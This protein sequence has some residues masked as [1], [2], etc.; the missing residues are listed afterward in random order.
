MIEIVFTDLRTTLHMLLLHLQHLDQQFP[1]ACKCFPALRNRE[2]LCKALVNWFIL[3]A[4]FL[5]F[6]THNINMECWIINSLTVRILLTSSC[7]RKICSAFCIIFEGTA[8]ALFASQGKNLFCQQWGN[9]PREKQYRRVRQTHSSTCY[10]TL[11]TK[12]AQ[13]RMLKVVLKQ[14]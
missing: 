14:K 7:E 9:D 12:E 11:R 8:H 4:W 2:E 1:S 13:L 6:T 5:P 10:A 3:K